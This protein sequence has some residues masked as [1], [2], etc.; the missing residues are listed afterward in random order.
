MVLEGRLIHSIRDKSPGITDFRGS[1]AHGTPCSAG[2]DAGRTQESSAPI[3]KEQ[4]P[5][6]PTPAAP[7]S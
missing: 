3:H 7:I 2:I 1:V 5:N 6:E 4:I